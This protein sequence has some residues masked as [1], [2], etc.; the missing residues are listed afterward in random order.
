[1]SR[2]ISYAGND[3][4]IP[5]SGDIGNCGNA[6][7]DKLRWRQRRS[8]ILDLGRSEATAGESMPER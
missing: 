1:M 5:G 8:V 6:N 4:D 3:A 2:P 7:A